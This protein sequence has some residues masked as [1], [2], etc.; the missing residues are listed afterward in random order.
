MITLNEAEVARQQ[1]IAE[2]ERLIHKREMAY[3]QKTHQDDTSGLISLIHFLN[4]IIENE[5][6][7]ASGE[8]QASNGKHTD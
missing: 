5:A 1:A 2:A 8:Q 3:A 4:V 6:V 7:R